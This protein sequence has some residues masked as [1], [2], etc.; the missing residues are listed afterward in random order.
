MRYYLNSEAFLRV[1]GVHADRGSTFIDPKRRD[2]TPRGRAQKTE[3]TEARP[4][5]KTEGQTF[6]FPRPCRLVRRRTVKGSNQFGVGQFL[7]G[8]LRDCQTEPLRIIHVLA[9]VKPKGLLI[10]VAEQVVGFDRNVG[11]VDSTLQQTPEVFHPIGVD[12]LP[13]V[14]Y[15]VVNH[16]MLVLVAQSFIRLQRVRGDC[17]ELR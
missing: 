13:N 11:P 17:P 6:R 12:I 1:R 10:N 4:K 5:T 8:N 16:L 9:V 15:G 14:F 3:S 7:P 2:S